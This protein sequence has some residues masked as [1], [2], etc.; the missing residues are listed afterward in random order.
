MEGLRKAFAARHA[1]EARDAANGALA[2]R[3]GREL[4]SLVERARAEIPDLELDPIGFVEHVADRHPLDVTADPLLPAIQAGDLWVAHGCTIQNPDAISILGSRYLPQVRSALGRSFDTGLAEDAEL[5]L[6]EKLLP[7]G[8]GAMSIASYSGRGR[9]LPWLRAAA[10]R[11]AIDL[12]R[13]RREVPTDPMALR[14][15]DGDIDPLLG[16]LKTRYRDAFHDAFGEAARQLTDRERTLLR[17]KF[18]DDL[19][20][21]EIGRLY[22]VNR[23]TVAR[24]LVAIREGLFEETRSRLGTKLSITETDVDSVLRLIDS[25]LDISIEALMK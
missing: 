20:I 25:Q 21:D 15:V 6:F 17:Y 18:V 16:A 9:L 3:L 2:D 13:A 22:R 19:S 4:D 7:S 11:C 24:W 12:M 14:D 10:V 23:A 8:D 1:P 5:K